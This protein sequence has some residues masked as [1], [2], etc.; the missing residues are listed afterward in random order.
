MGEAAQQIEPEVLAL[1]DELLRTSTAY[2]LQQM[3]LKVDGVPFDL[4]QY[5]YLWELYDDSI[6]AENGVVK[7]GAQMGFTTL[8][9]LLTIDRAQHLYPRGIL[10]LFPT[11][12]DVTVF[13]KTRFDR[14][15]SD[16]PSLS[17][18]V[19]G[20][21][22]ANV[23]KV[24]Q[25]FIY[26]RGAR[27]TEK[28]RSQLKSIPCDAI[29]YDEFDEMAPESVA[30]AEERLAGSQFKHHFRF[31]TPTYPD[32]G[33]DWEY[34]QTDQRVWMLKCGACNHS[35]VVEENFPDCLFELG[36]DE[37]YLAC[38]RCRGRLETISG[39]WVARHPSRKR[40]GYYIS[41]MNSPT[42]DLKEMLKA[43]RD[44]RTIKREFYNSKLGQAYADIADALTAALVKG[45]CGP[46][47]KAFAHPGPGFMGVDPGQRLIHYCV[48]HNIAEDRPKVV[49]FG[50]C[51]TFE[52]I[53]DLAHAFGVECGVMDAGAETRKVRDF[54]EGHG[55]WWGCLYDTARRGADL[56]DPKEK[57]IRCGRTETLD[58]SHSLVV[59]RIVE[60]PRPDDNFTDEVV[61]SM[62]NL[63]RIYETDEDTGQRKAKW[64]RRGAKNDDHRMAFNYA[65]M[66][67][68]AAPVY[69]KEDERFRKSQYGASRPRSFMSA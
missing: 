3:D 4:R 51:E 49:R 53:H 26:F 17:D 6:A 41:Q 28:S 11:K 13:S 39:E 43:W 45:C 50:T 15:M 64:V 18:L 63:V 20:T 14:I 24:G 67:A 54:V 36:D 56:W 30:L 5:P 55:E 35:Q 48:G 40:R 60:F 65:M 10:Y 21:D 62:C 59:N 22:S 33:V 31:S 8:M 37:V 61:P 12:D 27:T 47:P 2:R 7:K 66:A 9:V 16:N 57:M 25:T 19:Q 23:K 58:R 52:Q 32:Y 38:S 68:E 46:D 42:V 34:Q 69:R 1:H 29:V 44:P